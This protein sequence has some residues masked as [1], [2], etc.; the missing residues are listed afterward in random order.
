MEGDTEESC[1]GYQTLTH[2]AERYIVFNHEAHGTHLQHNTEIFQ[3]QP[4]KSDTHTQ[5]PLFLLDS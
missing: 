1:S 4:Q 5:T 2:T 3:Q